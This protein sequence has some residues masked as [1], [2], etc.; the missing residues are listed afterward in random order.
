MSDHFNRSLVMVFI[1]L[2]LSA[3]SL[4]PEYM[5]PVPPL[6]EKYTHETKGEDLS[7]AAGWREYFTDPDLQS[8]IEQTLRNNRDLRI[9]MLRIEE[10]R[11]VYGIQKANRLPT[12]NGSLSSEKGQ[13]AIAE[14]QKTRTEFYQI[15]LGLSDYELDF[16]GRVKSLSN[17]ALEEFLSTEE[18]RNN[19]QISLIAE[20]AN[21]YISVLALNERKQLT[22][23][24]LRSRRESL[25]RI[26]RRL[27]VGLDS[28]LEFKTAEMQVDTSL[29]SLSTIEREY[30]QGLNGLKLLL[31][32][33]S[34]EISLVKNI[35]NV[36]ISTAK[37]GIPSDLLQMR[38][39]VRAA[40][41]KL[42]AAN[43]NIGAAR[44]AF[45]PRI[46]LTTNVGL[47]NNDLLNLF[48]GNSNETWSFNPQ[49]LLPIFNN[50]RNQANLDLAEVR[51]DVAIAEYEKT[52]QIAFREVADVLAIKGKIENEV[53]L[54]TR[55]AES[56][57]VRLRLV[58]RRYDLGVA[59]YLELMDAQRNVYEVDQEL[60]QLK[61]MEMVNKISLYKALGGN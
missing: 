1:L 55:I 28:L 41:H 59:N 38:P 52:I 33:Q 11:S 58:T 42:I 51:K 26:K 25:G 54:Q 31:G 2:S 23:E 36:E 48:D 49:L 19:V 18:A 3:C 15:G 39:D 43:A 37:V 10:A 5:R 34:K 14:G 50:G 53:I 20:L 61:K 9:A 12:A 35:G 46:Q 30:E 47:V 27:D 7:L 24:T 16:F 17:V 44:A 21:S 13:S 29:V 8:L 45:F 6:P 32:D 40:E 56:D 57:Y 22:I 60:V 4:T